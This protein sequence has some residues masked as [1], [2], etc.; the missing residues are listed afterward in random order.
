MKVIQQTTATRQA[1]ID[2]WRASG[3]SQI[4][5]AQ[6]NGLGKTT[7][8]KWITLS[9]RA[10]RSPIVK[11]TSTFVPVVIGSKEIKT[12]VV[13][14]DDVRVSVGSAQLQFAQLSLVQLTSLLSLFE[15]CPC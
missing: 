9:N 14:F 3:L 8:Q 15:Q 2:A 12:E 6:E 4:R 10:N 11:A 1:H 5:Y 7:L 13:R